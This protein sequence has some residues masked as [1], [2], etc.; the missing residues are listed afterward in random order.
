MEVEGER[1]CTV[2]LPEEKDP[3]WANPLCV[4]EGLV[5]HDLRPFPVEVGQCIEMHSHHPAFIGHRIV[6]CPS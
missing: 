5:D 2:P 1:V 3:G 4:D 6:P